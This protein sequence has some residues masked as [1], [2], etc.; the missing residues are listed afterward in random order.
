MR[1]NSWHKTSEKLPTLQDGM[2][3]GLWNMPDGSQNVAICFYDVDDNTWYDDG[4]D[5]GVYGSFVR[6]PDYWTE[7]PAPSDPE[8]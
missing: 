4:G 2:V 7:I 1:E 8:E 5:L 6:Q 3:A